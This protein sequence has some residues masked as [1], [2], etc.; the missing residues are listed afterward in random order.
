MLIMHMPVIVCHLYF[1][2]EKY[3]LLPTFYQMTLKCHIKSHC[4]FHWMFICG[5][6]RKKTKK[7][8]H[9]NLFVHSSNGL[10]SLILVFLQNQSFCKF[11]VLELSGYLTWYLNK[12]EKLKLFLLLFSVF[13]PILFLLYIVCDFSQAL[14]LLFLF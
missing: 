6:P 1:P 2:S 8:R 3:I 7:H 9:V 11:C 10:N 12:E 4:I 14:R 5:D 13:I